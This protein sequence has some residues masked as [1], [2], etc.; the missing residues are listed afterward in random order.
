MQE[1]TVV[2]YA[3]AL[4]YTSF[5][6]DERYKDRLAPTVHH[7]WD[8]VVNPFRS[9]ALHN[10]DHSH[11]LGNCMCPNCG[12]KIPDYGVW[13]HIAFVCTPFCEGIES[14]LQYEH[15]GER[16]ERKAI[17]LSLLV[18]IITHAPTPLVQGARSWKVESLNT[19]NM[20]A[21]PA[22]S[23]QPNETGRGWQSRSRKRGSSR[24]H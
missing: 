7:F 8:E 20:K 5:C 21:G 14:H 11:L 24:H 12:A 1:C 19:G 16:G 3:W 6:N 22:V 13:E 9:R 10:L 2:Q 18:E 17:K 4:Q 23:P 15:E